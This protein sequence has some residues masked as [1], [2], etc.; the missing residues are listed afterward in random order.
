MAPVPANRRPADGH[1]KNT[2][3]VVAALRLVFLGQNRLTHGPKG[4]G[5][6]LFFCRETTPTRRLRAGDG[7]ARHPHYVAM[8]HVAGRACGA[9][10]A[11][12]SF[13]PVYVGPV[14]S[15]WS[16]LVCLVRYLTVPYLTVRYL[17]VLYIKV[18]TAV[19]GTLRYLIYRVL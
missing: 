3:W 10:P 11:Y 12:R 6:H 16:G 14:W 17:T 1:Q 9:G 2:Y 18:C 7:G 13:Q 15:V 8:V 19:Y 5:Y 4:H